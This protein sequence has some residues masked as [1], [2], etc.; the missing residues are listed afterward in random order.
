MPNIPTQEASHFDP[1]VLVVHGPATPQVPLVL[2][3]PHSGW[4]MP[5]DFN[6]RLSADALRD[7]EDCFIDQL[8]MPAT[9]RGVPLLAAQYPR[10]YLDP[11]RHA[12]DIDLALLE[13]EWPHEHVPSGKASI[14]KALIWR[15]LDD[16]RE[17]YD[18]KL[19]VDEIRSRVQRYHRP[20]H[21]ALRQLL[22]SAHQRFGA[23]YHINCH[24]M[25]AVSGTQGEGGKG[26]SR[27]DFVLGDRD[28]ST[29]TPEFTALVREQMCAHGYDVKIN[30]PFKGVELVRAYSHPAG[31]RHSL[32]VEINKR[33]YMNEARR[34]PIAHFAVLQSQL[35]QMIDAVCAHF[36]PQLKP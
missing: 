25:N 28:G 10:T 21:A 24:S 8:Y 5:E 30:D 36:S 31:G 18:R 35:M 32:Q 11:N 17:L 4:H 22:D 23:V 16:G 13:G 9:Q 29:C 14:G 2:D 26:Q 20:Y 12:G 1:R 34:E 27:A 6:S 33:L 19:S 7:G 3:S 15:T